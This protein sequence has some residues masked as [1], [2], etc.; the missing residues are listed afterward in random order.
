MSKTGNEFSS[1]SRDDNLDVMVI[2][3]MYGYTTY[4]R[5]TYVEP[6]GHAFRIPAQRSS[7]RGMALKEFDR[8]LGFSPWP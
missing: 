1:D 7:S 3:A 5:S 6:N 8:G 2:S 4:L